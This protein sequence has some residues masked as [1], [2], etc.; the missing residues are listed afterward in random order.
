MEKVHYGDSIIQF[1]IPKGWNVVAKG[2]PKEARALENEE[3]AIREALRNPIHSNRLKDLAKGKENAVIITSDYTRIVPTAAV[4]PIRDELNAGGIKDE[5][6]TLVMGGGSHVMATSQ[7]MEK[8]YGAKILNRLKAIPHNPDDNLVFIGKTS[9][10]TPIFVNN[11]VAEAELK[12]GISWVCPHITAGYSG[13]AKGILPGVCGRETIMIHHAK[14]SLHPNA[15]PGIL[16]E[17]PFRRDIEE[18]GR[19]VGL[20]FVVNVVLNVKKELVYCVAGDQEG[21]FEEAYSYCEKIF[22][23]EIPRKADVVITSGFPS[24]AHFYQSLK[25][26]AVAS[27]PIVRD[28]GTVI[29]STASYGGILEGTYKLFTETKGLLASD[30]VAMINRGM[31]MDP[32]V[33]GFYRPEVGL[34]LSSTL[35]RMLRE[36][37]VDVI[38]V[39]DNLSGD[40]LK[41]MGFM[42]A[43]SLDEAITIAKAK[44]GKADVVVLPA[45]GETITKLKVE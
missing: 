42:H 43:V 31:R 14:H 18:A 23:L 12:V 39:S 38:V 7:Q 26:V 13:G 15:K 8:V 33:V 11:V 22:C 34:G 32:K 2:E 19:L 21:A 41:E 4:I 28:G 29:H 6:I 1:E 24:E 5:D 10:N 27:N 45:G 36:R 9:F 16:K 3:E 25:G 37:D 30:I 40:K 17:N 35:L 20:D 44:H